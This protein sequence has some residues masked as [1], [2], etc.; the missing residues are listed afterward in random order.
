[1]AKKRA[2]KV[3][4]T[5]GSWDP[6]RPPVFFMVCVKGK[7]TTGGQV[8]M[9]PGGCSANYP[10]RLT[11]ATTTAAGGR[12]VLFPFTEL[13]G[14]GDPAAWLGAEGIGRLMIDSGAFALASSASK[15]L[16][17]VSIGG[18]FGM[19]LE[20]V[21]GGERALADYEAMLGAWGGL[22][23]GYV[24]FDIG[25]TSDRRARREGQEARGICPIPVYSALNDPVEYFEELVTGYDR[26][27]VGSIARLDRGA[28]IR[29]LAAL[30]RVYRESGSRAWVHLLG[31][32][33]GPSTAWA[34]SMDA[35]NW[36]H[37]AMFGSEQREFCVGGTIRLPGSFNDAPRMADHEDCRDWAIARRVVIYRACAT[38]A[39]ARARSVYAHRAEQDEFTA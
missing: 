19:H 7:G 6:S 17:G 36:A 31:C 21:P 16:A 18:V 23:W 28:K 29:V 34:R 14:A 24:E 33:P 38:I 2:G 10:E 15:E 11:S 37:S 27:A 30:E 1:M 3:K 39:L 9:V 20:D 5:G 12:D 25:C 26:V 22:S 8:D 13:R 35:S 32:S 4:R